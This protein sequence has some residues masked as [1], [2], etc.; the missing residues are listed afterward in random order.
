MN[1]LL[2]LPLL[3]PGPAPLSSPAPAA[4]QDE[5]PPVDD[6]EDIEALI[7]QLDDHAGERG[8]EDQEAIAVIDRLVIEFPGCGPKDRA[9]IVKALDKCFSEKRKEEDGVRQNQLYMAATVAMGEMFPESVKPLL[10]WIDHKSHRQDLA[11]QRMLIR[12]VGKSKDEKARKELVKL[13]KHHEAQIQAAAAEALGEYEEAE[14]DVR[15]ETFEEL[16]KLMMSVK[17]SVDSDPQNTIARQRWDVIAA[18]IVTS[19]KRLSGHD[20]NDPNQWQHWWNKNKREDWDE[21]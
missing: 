13:L 10:S 2:I 19:L 21:A 18:P 11:L 15:K 17:G 1:A 9:A 16:L 12:T 14:L 3:L 8:K 20:E 7:E 5:E 4:F 6:R